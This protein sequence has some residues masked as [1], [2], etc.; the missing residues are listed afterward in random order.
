VAT[1]ALVARKP[2]QRFAVALLLLV[3]V[4]AVPEAHAQPAGWQPEKSVELIASSAPG[5]SNDKTA[6]TMQKILQDQRLVLMPVNVINKPGGNQTLARVYLNQHA[7][8]PHYFDMGNPTLLSNHIS[9]IT[10]QHYSDFSPI[11]LLLNEYTVF[12][13]RA[14][15]PIR[16]ARD[17]AERLRKDP[18]SF[19]VG[20]SNRGGT[21]HLTLALIAKS[22]GVDPKRL[23]VVVFK[24]NA[25]S[26]SAVL[27]GHIQMVASTVT[28]VIG[29]VA[30]GNARFIGFGAPRRM[31][32]ALAAVPTLREQGIDVSLSNWRAI[33]GPRGL[34]PEQVSFWEEVLA[35]AVTAEDWKKSLEAQNWEG[36]FL[37]SGD[38]M[39]YLAQQ[40][41]LTKGI[42]TDLGLA[43]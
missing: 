10:P 18:E 42:L 5:G 6:R 19:T 3:G 27:G 20:I 15:S 33:I 21:N 43:K 34:A 24:S 38:F 39:K 16:T 37:R 8:D 35:K 31:P 40:Y 36:H 12:T 11:A 2:G 32:G 1:D 25:E 7:G 29:Q 9:G 22:V 41:E 30:A 28:A 26:V 14:D 23:K 13:V 4:A 17:L